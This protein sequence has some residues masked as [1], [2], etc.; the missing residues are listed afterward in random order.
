MQGE[1]Y[2]NVFTGGSEYQ[3]RHNAINDIYQ[4]FVE[5]MK[6]ANADYDLNL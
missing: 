2:T 5:D 1:F 4:A 3:I 6:C